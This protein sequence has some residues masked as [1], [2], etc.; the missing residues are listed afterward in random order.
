MDQKII[1][2]AKEWGQNSYFLETDRKEILDL[3]SD[4]AKHEAELNERFYRDLEFGTGGLRAPMG[5]GKN[6]MNKYNVRRATQALANNVIKNFGTGSA[7]VSYDSRNN[8]K[9]FAMEVAE[10]L[11]RME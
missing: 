3:L 10:F 2:N 9:A 11:R 7:V 1:Q 6:R 4:T 5:M 8:S